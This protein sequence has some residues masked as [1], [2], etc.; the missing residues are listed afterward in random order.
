MGMKTCVMR[1]AA[2]RP[3]SRDEIDRR[4]DSLC[5]E[6][7][8]SAGDEEPEEFA[9]CHPRWICASELVRR[10]RPFLVLN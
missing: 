2:I 8:A 9:G 3:L 10:M 1:P 5:T 4:I 7:A 6:M